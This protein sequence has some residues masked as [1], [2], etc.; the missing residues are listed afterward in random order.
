MIIIMI[1][2]DLLRSL[3]RGKLAHSFFVTVTSFLRFSSPSFTPSLI[4]SLSLPCLLLSLLFIPEDLAK[5]LHFLLYL[6]LP[7]ISC[8]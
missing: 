3:N 7:F 8:L 5:L 1:T 6:V 2:Q 4:P